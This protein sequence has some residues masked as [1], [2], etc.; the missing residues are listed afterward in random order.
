MSAKKGGGINRTSSIGGGGQ[1]QASRRLSL[2]SA[3]MQPGTPDICRNG[4]NPSRLGA[5]VGK[6]SK[7]ERS[8]PSAPLN[9]VA[10]NKD[11]TATAG[12][13]APTSPRVR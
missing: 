4:I 5:S 12:G 10:L 8:R 1:T 7:R 11:D 2:G 3:I 6:D 9:Y 13:S